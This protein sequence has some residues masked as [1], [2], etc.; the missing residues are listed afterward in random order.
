[1]KER[2]VYLRVHLPR[3][4]LERVVET[5]R[6]DL[7]L[8]LVDLATWDGSTTRLD[9]LVGRGSLRMRLVVGDHVSEL[10]LYFLR[11]V[12]TYPKSI[13][14][15]AHVKV[16]VALVGICHALTRELDTTADVEP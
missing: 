6:E 5:D 1:M 15:R 16:K 2:C 11:Q 8:A 9:R 4:G 12:K 14:V 10:K 7:V 13:G 3:W